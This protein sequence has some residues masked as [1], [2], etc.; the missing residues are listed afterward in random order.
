MQ[1]DNNKEFPCVQQTN[2]INKVSSFHFSEGLGKSVDK[3][4]LGHWQKSEQL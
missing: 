2:S 4:V 1:T 3:G